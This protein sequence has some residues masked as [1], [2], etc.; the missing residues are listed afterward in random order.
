M[1]NDITEMQAA[2]RAKI[3]QTG[4]SNININNNREILVELVN[5]VDNTLGLDLTGATDSSVA[6]QTAIDEASSGDVIKLPSGTLRLES[7]VNIDK[8]ISI[9]GDNTK[10]HIIGSIKGFYIDSDLVEVKGVKFYADAV[11]SGSEG[12]SVNSKNEFNIVEC[13]FDTLDYGIRFY[14]TKLGGRNNVVSNISSCYAKSCTYGM[15]S[16]E[17]GEYVN[18]TASR[19]YLCTTA[20]SI[21]GG[22]VMLDGCQITQCTTGVELLAG[23]NNSHGIISNCQINHNSTPIK[24]D[25]MTKGHTIVGCHIY[26]GLVTL[27]DSI[28]VTFDNCVLVLTNFYADNCTAVFV[29]NCRI[30]EIYGFT[31]DLSYNGN[32]STVVSH[33]NY[34]YDTGAVYSGI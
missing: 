1:A 3:Q 20:A 32:A 21:A 14:N 31:V 28:G 26:Q 24:A 18:I 29:K 30:W 10:V 2:I 34:I 23:A 15:V 8:S 13:D 4:H 17:N 9:L 27:H 7:Q 16:E 6:L 19:F 12:I 25:A 22:N 5:W 33:N 11:V